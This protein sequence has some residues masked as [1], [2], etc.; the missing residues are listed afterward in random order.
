MD[1]YRRMCPSPVLFLPDDLMSSQEKPL[2]SSKEVVISVSLAKDSDSDSSPSK[3][4]SNQS[5][6][7]NIRGETQS[8]SV[9]YQGEEEKSRKRVNR[10]SYCVMWCDLQIPSLLSV[11][12]NSVC[13]R[14]ASSLRRSK[15]KEPSTSGGCLMMG[16][17]FH[18]TWHQHQR[19]TWSRTNQACLWLQVWLCSFPSCSLTEASGVTVGSASSS[20]ARSTGLITTV[21]REL[22]VVVLYHRWTYI[23][24]IAYASV[25]IFQS[26][27]ATLLSRFR[28]DFSD[29]IVLGDINTKPKKHK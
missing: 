3:T 12:L 7:I 4:T 23:L 17:G 22:P 2:T 27:M 10:P 16:V 5:S 29:I 14:A 18:E 13:W 28:I 26:R 8:S 21:E 20:A 11:R 19:K 1:C 25:R 15:A 24:R 6:L 9:S